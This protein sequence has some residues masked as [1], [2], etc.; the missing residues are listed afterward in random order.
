[1]QPRDKAQLAHLLALAMRE[2]EADFPNAKRCILC[3]RPAEESKAGTLTAGGVLGDKVL[4]I[5]TARVCEKCK[6]FRADEDLF[7]RMVLAACDAFH[8]MIDG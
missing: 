6:V 2:R 4:V 1:M 3:K 8:G 5:L 7:S